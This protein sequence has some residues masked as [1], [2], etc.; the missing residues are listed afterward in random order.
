MKKGVC[1]STTFPERT[2]FPITMRPAVALKENPSR[3]NRSI[4]SAEARIA[5]IRAASG[6]ME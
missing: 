6:R 3:M 2:S 4:Q 5:S 1:S